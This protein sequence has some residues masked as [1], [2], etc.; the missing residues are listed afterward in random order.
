MASSGVPVSHAVT[1]EC[2]VLVSRYIYVSRDDTTSCGLSVSLHV[3]VSRDVAG[4]GNVWRRNDL[5]NLAE[6]ASDPLLHAENTYG[7]P[8]RNLA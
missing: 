8:R 4:Q 5:L 7:D 2:Y 1:S 3:T 6:K